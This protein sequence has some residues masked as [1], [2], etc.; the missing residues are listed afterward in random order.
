MVS[1][2]KTSK[3]RFFLLSENKTFFCD[4]VLNCSICLSFDVMRSDNEFQVQVFVFINPTKGF[5]FKNSLQ[6]WLESFLNCE[7]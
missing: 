1:M 7:I 5:V 2:I 3:S 6:Q 4:V